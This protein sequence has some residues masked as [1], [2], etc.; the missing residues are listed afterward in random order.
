MIAVELIKQICLFPRTVAN[1]V[2]LK[3]QQIV[4][5]KENDERLDR[6]RN[7]SNYQGR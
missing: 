3:Q 5:K 2:K 7:P 6:I 1:A 4:L